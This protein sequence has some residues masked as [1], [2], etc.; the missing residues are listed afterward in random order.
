MQMH[1]ILLSL[2]LLCAC[3]ASATT[4]QVGPTQTLTNLN[5]VPWESL[6]AGDTVLIDYSPTPYNQKWVICRRGTATAPITVRGVA[7]PNGELPIISGSNAT[8][9][10]TLN[11]WGG[12]R[13]LIKIGGAS[14]PADAMPRYISIENLE[15]CNARPPF[16][17][18]NL[19]ATAGAYQNMAAGIWIEKGENITI[20]NCVVHDC[21]NGIFVSS[22]TAV[23][24]NVVVEGCY[25]YGNGNTNSIYEHNVYTEALGMT[26]QYNRFGPLRAG[27]PGNNLKDRSAGLVVRNNWIEGGNRELDLVDAEDS[28]ALQGSPLYHQTYV[29]GN[30]LVEPAGDGNNQIVHYGGDSGNASA[31][32]KGTLYFYNNTVI[33]KRTD[34]A[35]MFRLDTNDEHCDARNNVFYPLVATSGLTLTDAAGVL[36][37]TNNW[38]RT[39]YNVSSSALAGAVNLGGTVLGASP[40]FVNEAGGDYHLATNSACR[41]AGTMLNSAVLP[42]NNVTNEY[43]VDRKFQARWNDGRFD[44]GAFEVP[45]DPFVQVN[46]PVIT[47]QPGG[48]TA[49]LGEDVIFEVTAIGE[50]LQYQWKRGA[51]ALTDG[52]TVVGAKTAALTLRGVGPANVG[53][54]SAAV[55]NGA[56]LVNSAAASLTVTNPYA[57]LGGIYNGLFYESDQVRPAHAGFFTVTLKTNGIFSGNNYC[58]GVNRA[59]S[60]RFV[61]GAAHVTVATNPAIAMDMTLDLMGTN[62]AITGNVSGTN[63]TAPLFGLRAGYTNAA[64]I[65]ESVSLRSESDGLLA[66]G[67]DG[68]GV[69]TV[70]T[71]GKYTLTGTLSDGAAFSAIAG[72]LSQAGDWPFYAPVYTNSGVVIGW[73]T[74]TSG[75]YGGTLA[76]IKPVRAG[77]NYLNGFTNFVD[78]TSSLL[79]TLSATNRALALTNAVVT[80]SDGSLPVAITNHVVLTASNTF[81][82]AAG[83][84][85]GLKLSLNLNTAQ[86]TGSFT[87]PV[88]KKVNNLKGIL[89]RQQGEVRGFYS[90][91]QTGRFL[92]SGE[93]AP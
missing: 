51:T 65:R 79:P 53:S 20:S 67:G 24:T 50:F 22:G 77:T 46:L 7:G 23:S 88:S 87:N 54:Y 91:P 18:T 68:F 21:G 60:G 45:G 4:Y 12:N 93:G 73:L 86:V 10:A 47:I 15:I 55:K 32:R 16:T 82:V 44:I 36:N 33:S 26:F 27:C 31:Y 78:V 43:V 57:T 70:S 2:L 84:T 58:K 85:N 59:I 80:L 5:K 75:I 30:V 62:G 39:K 89:M 49:S 83:Q 14:V 13:S 69:A 90:S 56:G 64:A 25:I 40:G 41:N 38:I 28:T 34:N 48:Q 92:L 72:S 37:A 19:D 61:D 11:Y 81:V 52:A 71:N 1:K 6:N 8:T 63:W 76:W 42:D 66:P 74:Q 9:R 35:T 3:A 17:Y 29:Y